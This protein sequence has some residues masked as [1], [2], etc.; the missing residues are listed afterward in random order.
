MKNIFLKWS[1][2]YNSKKVV[3]NIQSNP[4]AFA[5][6]LQSQSMGRSKVA[7]LPS[8]NRRLVARTQNKVSP[9]KSSDP[10]T[11]LPAADSISVVTWVKF[12][13]VAIG[14]PGDGNGAWDEDSRISKG[15]RFS[16]R[17]SPVGGDEAA[18]GECRIN[19]SI[20]VSV[21]WPH[22]WNTLHTYEL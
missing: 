21:L 8:T 9:A 14:C 4:G 5:C 19:S 6:R 20:G 13:D 22:T 7:P 17:A 2:Y 10:P 3:Y 16:R 12:W 18:R 11:H 1:P 15:G